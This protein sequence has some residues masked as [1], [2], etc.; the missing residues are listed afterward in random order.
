MV[1]QVVDQIKCDANGEKIYQGTVLMG[2]SDAAIDRCKQEAVSDLKRLTANT[3]SRLEWSDMKL[4][5]VLLVFIETQ[6]WTKKA[7]TKSCDLEVESDLMILHS[8]KSKV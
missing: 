2:Y 3:L 6:S 5:R 7:S 4:L 8:Q 1:K